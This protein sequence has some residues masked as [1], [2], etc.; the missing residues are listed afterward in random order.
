V[1]AGTASQSL[2]LLWNHSIT[3]NDSIRFTAEG[4]HANG[5]QP[6]GVSTYSAK[7]MMYYEHDF[8]DGAPIA[9]WFLNATFVHQSGVR[10][11]TAAGGGIDFPLSRQPVGPF[12][13]IGGTVLG[14]CNVSSGNHCGHIE[15]DVTLPFQ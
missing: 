1:S 11:I 15:F 14:A 2:A 3:K 13:K 6:I 4:E 10:N 5:T 8:A 12:S 9:D 7:G